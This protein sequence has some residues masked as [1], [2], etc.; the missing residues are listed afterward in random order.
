M[1]APHKMQYAWSM[2]LHKIW[3]W[4][5]PTLT[6]Q[7]KHKGSAFTRRTLKCQLVFWVTEASSTTLHRLI[8]VRANSSSQH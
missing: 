5:N 7:N 6:I 3:Y 8:G 2:E 1:G 4:W